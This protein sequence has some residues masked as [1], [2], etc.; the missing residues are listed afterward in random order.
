MA[1]RRNI[2]LSLLGDHMHQNRAFYFGRFMK[3]PYHCGNIVT[4]HRSEIDD[5]HIFKVHPRYHELLDAALGLMD[6]PYDLFSVN[7]YPAQGINDTVFQIL[8]GT[9]RPDAAQIF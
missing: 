9:R 6:I 2:A 1:L 7:R 8:I 5:P 4:V 3:C